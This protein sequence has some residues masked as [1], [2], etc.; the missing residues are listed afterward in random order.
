M[1]KKKIFCDDEGT[2]FDSGFSGVLKSD[3][4]SEL[5][6]VA[7]TR[8]FLNSKGRNR[9]DNDNSLQPFVYSHT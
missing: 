7:V 5:F 9:K 8:N 2:L 1:Q 4:K 3:S 6:T